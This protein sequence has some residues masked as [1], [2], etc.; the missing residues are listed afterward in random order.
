M[1]MERSGQVV[2]RHSSSSASALAAFVFAIFVL[3]SLRLCDLIQSNLRASANLLSSLRAFVTFLG[4]P[5]GSVVSRY[6]LS[7]P[8]VEIFLLDMWVEIFLLDM[9]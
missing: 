7:S 5:P 8:C 2:T 1:I 6:L 9:W 4:N 3:S